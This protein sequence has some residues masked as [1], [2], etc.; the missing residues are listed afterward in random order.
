MSEE[1]FYCTCC[2]HYKYVSVRVMSPRG[3]PMCRS[4]GEKA[5]ANANAETLRVKSGNST[6]TLAKRK[7]IVAKLTARR[8]R[9]GRL[10]PDF[11]Q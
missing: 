6:T 11:A 1:R 4:C 3:R 10:P 7:R 2:S 5:W 8:Y 9:E